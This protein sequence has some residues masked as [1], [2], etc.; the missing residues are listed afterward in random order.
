MLKNLNENQNTDIEEL[1]HYI[2]V[3]KTSCK[4]QLDNYSNTTHNKF[5]LSIEDINKLDIF[6]QKSY[7]K[8]IKDLI[9]HYKNGIDNKLEFNII[10]VPVATTN[11]PLS[12]NQIEY[13]IMKYC[14]KFEKLG[15]YAL[16]INSV[17]I[18]NR[19]VFASRIYDEIKYNEGKC[20][21]SYVLNVSCSIKNLFYNKL[22]TL[23]LEIKK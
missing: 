23:S 5:N 14:E 4:E 6:F 11:N 18:F 15:L 3:A 12:S 8:V 21:I 2:E 13:L 9:E 10:N 22:K 7:I 17:K 19:P 20:H 1:K 16:G